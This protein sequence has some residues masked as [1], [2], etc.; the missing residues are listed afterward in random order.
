MA[1][2]VLTP[3]Q[4]QAVETRGGALLVSAAAG[5]GKTRVLVDRVLGRLCDPDDPKNINDF[6]IITYTKAAAQELRGKIAAA[7]SESLSLQPEN[8]HLARQLSRIYLAQISTVHAFCSTLLRDYAHELGV[9]PDFRIA[10]ET[11][12]AEWQQQAMDR[13][14]TDAY[15]GLKEHPDCRAFL[16]QLGA[17]RDDRTAARILMQAYNSVQ[18]HPDPK[19]WIGECLRV[20]EL[21]GFKDMADTDWGKYLKKE[22]K[23]ILD[24]QIQ[25]MERGLARLSENAKAEEKYGP[26]FRMNL[27]QLRA[28]QKANTWDEIH[29]GRITDFGKLGAVHGV[30]KKVLE[31]LKRPRQQ[32]IKIMKEAQE[33]F[34]MP[35]GEALEEL[36]QGAPVIRGMFRLVECFN[37]HYQAI[38]QQHRAMDF[39]DLEHETLRLL[40]RGDGSLSNAA[41]EIRSRFCEVMVDEYQDSNAVQDRIFAGVS[42]DGINL[43]MVGDVK[44]S[45]YRFR[46]ADPGI[47]IQKYRTYRDAAD[48]RGEEPRRVMLS[49]NFRSR[50]E[51]LSAVNDIFSLCMS[52]RVGDVKYGEAEKLRPGLEAAPAERPCVELHCLDTREREEGDGKDALEARLVAARIGT[53]IREGRDPGDIVILLR[54][55]RAHAQAY[56]HALHERGIE[57]VSDQSDDILQTS[58]VSV[59]LSYLQILDNP[60]QDIPLLSVLLSPVGGFDAEQVARIRA[61]RRSGDFYDALL[62]YSD[63]NDA[64]IAFLNQLEGL[65]TASRQEHVG[66]LVRMVCEQTGLRDLF[67]AMPD[68]DQRLE[69]LRMIYQMAA[70]FDPDGPGRVH[71]FLARIERQRDRGISAAGVSNP[72][73]V[74]IMS[75][76]KSKG[77][78]FPVVVVAGLSTKFNT[79]DDRQ[80]VQIHPALGTGCDVVD[81]TRRI[82]YSSLAKQ[83]ILHRQREERISEEL[84]VLYVALTRPKELL[85]MTY[86]SASLSTKL[87]GIADSLTPDGPVSLS[88]RAD[89]LGHWVLMAAMRRS[90]A[91]ELFALG[92]APDETAGSENPWAIRLWTPDMLPEIIG[93]NAEVRDEAPALPDNVDALINFQYP[94]SAATSAPAKLTATQF[95]G[96]TLDEES[97]EGTQTAR[98]SEYTLRQPLFLQ[99]RRPLSPTERGNAVHL[100]MQ[101]I[102]YECC[103][104]EA[105]ILRELKRL[106]DEGFLTEPQAEAVTPEKILAL[107]SSDL[108][109]RILNAP[110]A[111][112]E[113]K[114]SILTDAA[115]HDRALAGEKLLLQGVTDCCLLEED[116]LVVIDFKTDRVRPGQEQAR[117]E[118]YRGQLEAYSLALSRIFE[119]PVKEKCLYF[120]ATD[121]AVWLN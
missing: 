16:D 51:I 42:R 66:V 106:V 39:G 100:A 117:A 5:S 56:L 112:R 33:V 8:R 82:K 74:H 26:T 90:E 6:L 22:F 57:A 60:H 47:F 63:E 3:Q 72:N 52:S 65:R 12:C 67:A 24:E 95:K 28:L 62:A 7:I 120:F 97:A 70:G 55:M 114:F 9:Y 10:D 81:L 13:T 68:G 27:D 94:Y 25:S 38:K 92:G 61:G 111:V 54:S 15:I 115:V 88:R 83:A 85:I 34:S 118:Y 43:F 71:D 77:L 89:C 50:P 101:Y 96:R 109:R 103:E 69:N 40:Y 2:I 49:S 84:R 99:G 116:G 104:N 11:E 19:G 86:T 17:G 48:A 93:Q 113:F 80:A 35:S 64:F 102:R 75:I 107:F 87:Q 21:S 121:Q 119:R 45:I 98:A 37:T 59:L 44:Q 29:R 108:G 110:E 32:C 4:R 31:R 78:E 105:S 1:D 79:E 30:D 46:L 76:H 41:W 91:G 23:T 53:L 58:E 20:L 14:L 18:C 73:A 36:R